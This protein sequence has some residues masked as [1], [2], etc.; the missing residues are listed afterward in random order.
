MLSVGKASYNVRA[1]VPSDI[2][3]HNQIILAENLKSQQHLNDI[4]EWTDKMKMKLNVGKTKN[5]IFNF[6]KKNQFTTKLFVN[7]K[8]I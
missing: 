8:N 4:S 2:P 1:H 6:S 5:M 7:D 3:T